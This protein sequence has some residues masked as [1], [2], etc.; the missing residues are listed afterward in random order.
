[1]RAGLNEFDRR[2]NYVNI[3]FYRTM[4]YVLLMLNKIGMSIKRCTFE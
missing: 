3:D 1:M 2:H 4:N